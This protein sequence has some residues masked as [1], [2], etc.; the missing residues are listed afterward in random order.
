MLHGTH[1][2]IEYHVLSYLFVTSVLVLCVDLLLGECIL[3][4]LCREIKNVKP[5]L[6]NEAGTF[7][8]LSKSANT[9]AS[10]PPQITSETTL[11]QLSGANNMI[12]KTYTH[13]TDLNR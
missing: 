6:V 5:T 8:L 3:I 11:N 4:H 2:S 9:K 1:G 13:P 12:K 10:R 7:S